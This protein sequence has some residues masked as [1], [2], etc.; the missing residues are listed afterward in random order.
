MLKQENEIFDDT[1]AL[2]SYLVVSTDLSKS[3][4][5]MKQSK[6]KNLRLEKLLKRDHFLNNRNLGFQHFN[7]IT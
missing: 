2:C 3:R 4:F 5:L 1:S 6:E 7:E